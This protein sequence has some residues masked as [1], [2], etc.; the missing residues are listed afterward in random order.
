M[1]RY[2]KP[3]RGASADVPELV[4]ELDA[5]YSGNELVTPMETEECSYG[6]LIRLHRYRSIAANN[7]PTSLRLIAA[8]RTMHTEITSV[9]AKTSLGFLVISFAQA[10]VKKCAAAGRLAHTNAIE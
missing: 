2:D 10:F 4:L 3:A 9:E 8:E 7:I 6:L 1:P 5:A